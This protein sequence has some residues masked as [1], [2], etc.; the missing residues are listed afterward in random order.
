M[1]NNNVIKKEFKNYKKTHGY[2]RK[3][4]IK[5]LAIVGSFLMI[6]GLIGSIICYL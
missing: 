4:I 3:R 5:I 1:K 2:R 6:S